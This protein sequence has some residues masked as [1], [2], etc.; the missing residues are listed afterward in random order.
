MK[1]NRLFQVR[2][3]TA[4]A[5]LFWVALASCQKDSDILSANDTQKV[6]NESVAASVTNDAGDIATSAVGGMAVSDYSGSSAG[7]RE[8]GFRALHL[9]R[10][11]ERLQCAVITISRTGTRLHP[12]GVIVINFDSLSSTCKDS[13]GVRRRGKII[14]TYDGIRWMP[15]SWHNVRLVNY[16][17]NDTHIQGNLTITTQQADTSQYLMFKSVLDSGAVT[18]PNGKTITREHTITREWVRAGSPLND[19]WITLTE[20]PVDHSLST[21]NGTFK[22]GESYFMQVTK[23]LVVKVSCRLEGVYTPVQGEKVI[24]FGNEQITIDYGN[25]SCDN[26]ITITIKGKEKQ[27]S[28]NESGD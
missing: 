17:R 2:N 28:I 22:N 12:H 3:I 21:A 10:I 16:Y 11:D 24:T 4:V 18:F 8:T 14:I 15:G 20:N 9:W 13:H 7:A 27:L 1:K 6:N 5:V 23:D 26:T 19:E 25:G